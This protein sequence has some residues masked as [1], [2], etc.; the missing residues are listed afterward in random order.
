MRVIIYVWYLNNLRQKQNV[1]II[2]KIV[3]LLLNV[4][5][6]QKIKETD[7]RCKKKTIKI[8]VKNI[9]LDNSKL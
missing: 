3:Y 5:R 9:I 1:N 2:T 8:H 7:M 4:F 6:E